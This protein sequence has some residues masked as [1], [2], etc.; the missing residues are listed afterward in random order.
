MNHTSGD[1][2]AV[3]EATDLLNSLAA[4]QQHHQQQQ[5]EQVGQ[6]MNCLTHQQANAAAMYA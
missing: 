5:Q 1:S 2:A 6:H 3:A 4:Q